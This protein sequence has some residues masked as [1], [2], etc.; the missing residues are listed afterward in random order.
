MKWLAVSLPR[1]KTKRKQ[2]FRTF[3]SEGNVFLL[4]PKYRLAHLGANREKF[5][6]RLKTL[7]DLPFERQMSHAQARA[8]GRV[9]PIDKNGVPMCRW[10]EKGIPEHDWT[11]ATAFVVIDPAIPDKFGRTIPH[12]GVAPSAYLLPIR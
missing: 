8:M 4:L 3:S 12:P 6:E 2:A 9:V 7:S 11:A 1:G 10:N 5:V